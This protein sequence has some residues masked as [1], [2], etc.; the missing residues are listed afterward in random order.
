[1]GIQRINFELGVRIDEP[2]T[3]FSPFARIHLDT[4][5]DV[6]D[7]DSSDWTDLCDDSGSP[8]AFATTASAALPWYDDLTD[9]DTAL[10]PAENEAN[11]KD[12]L[13]LGFSKLK[14]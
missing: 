14:L 7:I 11:A 2:D 13:R 9:A 6:Y 8:S 1:M 12:R 10:T 3:A 5:T 4:V